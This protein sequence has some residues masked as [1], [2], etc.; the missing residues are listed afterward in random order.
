MERL[1]P[2]PSFSVSKKIKSSFS[3]LNVRCRCLT[4]GEVPDCEFKSSS[5]DSAFED[6][7]PLVSNSMCLYLTHN[8]L[9]SRIHPFFSYL[10]HLKSAHRCFLMNRESLD[11][12][13]IR[14]VVPKSWGKQITNKWTKQTNKQKKYKKYRQKK[15]TKTQPKNTCFQKGSKLNS[16]ITLFYTFMEKLRMCCAQKGIEKMASCGVADVPHWGRL[17]QSIPEDHKDVARSVRIQPVPED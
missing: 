15:Q 16:A 9:C 13:R 14:M 4:K 8:T 12:V 6:S 10:R 17:Q 5:G 2:N 7:I 3:S 1:V 11:L